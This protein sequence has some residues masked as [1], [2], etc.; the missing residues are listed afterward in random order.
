[1]QLAIQIAGG[2][3]WLAILAGLLLLAYRSGKLAGGL[4]V[5]SMLAMLAWR[6]WGVIITAWLDSFLADPPDA[7]HHTVDPSN[8]ASVLLA[9][10]HFEAIGQACEAL[11][12][13][14][15][16]LAFVLA[17]LSVRRRGT[18]TTHSS[19]PNPLRGSA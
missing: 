3:A 18:R 5:A 9:M 10:G 14:W 15:F 8:A 2:A 7:T 16:A 11:M 17:V 4:L 19:E 1:M 6:F 12:L 13:L